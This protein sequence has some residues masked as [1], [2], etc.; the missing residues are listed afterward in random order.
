MC[1]IVHILDPLTDVYDVTYKGVRVFGRRGDDNFDYFLRQIREAGGMDRFTTMAD[2]LFGHFDNSIMTFLEEAEYG[3]SFFGL[4]RNADLFDGVGDVIFRGRGSVMRYFLDI[5]KTRG[6]PIWTL[7]KQQM[8]DFFTATLRSDTFDD[9]ARKLRELGFNVEP[10]DFGMSPDFRLTPEHLFVDDLGRTYGDV[11]IKMTGSRNLDY[12]EAFA[13]AG[14]DPADAA[15]YTWHHLDDFDPDGLTCTMQL[16]RTVIH[17]QV[18]HTGAVRM[19]EVLYGGGTRVMH[20]A[21]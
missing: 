4:R 21:S 18:D 14:I 9:A 10:S 7:V 13:R 8:D 11:S 17:S 2:D 6:T 16:V 12:A 3:V 15:G 20:Y 19:W 5:E 1:F